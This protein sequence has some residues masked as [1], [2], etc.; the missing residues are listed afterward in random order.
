MLRNEGLGLQGKP[1]AANSGMPG[2]IELTPSEVVLPVRDLD[3]TRHFYQEVLGCLGG[4]GD[5]ER[6]HFTLFDYPIAC[7]LCSQWVARRGVASSDTAMAV[8]AAPNPSL[9]VMLGSDEWHALVKRLRCYRAEFAIA[10]CIRFSG[11]QFGEASLLL[12]DPSGNV[13]EFRSSY[14]L[15]RA[16]SRGDRTKA[17]AMLSF[18]IATALV[19]CWIL[20]LAK[21]P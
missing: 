12:F 20:L 15:I 9:R 14:R 13:L 10:P 18:A 21:R 2:V 1:A 17:L 3:E 4:H 6:I 7:H 16:P 8:E 19:W 5:G 11:A